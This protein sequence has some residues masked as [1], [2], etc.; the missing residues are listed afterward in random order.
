MGDD[1]VSDNSHE[2]L[3]ALATKGRGHEVQAQRRDVGAIDVSKHADLKA[4][5]GQG[6]R[7]RLQLS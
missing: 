3:G 5:A 6:D 1:A 7:I 4:R 2:A